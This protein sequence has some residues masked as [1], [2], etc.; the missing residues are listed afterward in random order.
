[1]IEHVLLDTNGWIA[2]LNT[3]DN[4]HESARRIW[5]QL[6]KQKTPIVVTDWVVAETGNGLARFTVRASFQRAVELIESSPRSS[7]VTI[8][9]ELRRAALRLY[10]DR[11]DKTWGLVDCASFELM[12]GR[13][14]RSAFTDDQHFKQA[15][16]RRL[17]A[18]D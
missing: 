15:G 2:L 6:A 1:V 16:F 9:K 17:L 10:N 11:P 8:D 5:A 14:I 4:L 7:L 3:S 12:K 18:P 13:G